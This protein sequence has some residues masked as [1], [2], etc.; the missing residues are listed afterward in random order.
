MRREKKVQ[1]PFEVSSTAAE[2]ASGGLS[3]AGWGDADL[4]EDGATGLPGD[5]VEPSRWPPGCPPRLRC[6][7]SPQLLTLDDFVY[8]EQCCPLRTKRSTAVTS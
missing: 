8:E 4:P 3:E 6:A 7:S 1:V 5:G 2:I